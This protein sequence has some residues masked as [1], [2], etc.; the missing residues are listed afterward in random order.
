[1]EEKSICKITPEDI[2][3]LEKIAIGATAISIPASV[4]AAYELCLSKT[5]QTLM[6]EL[7]KY[8]S[9]ARYF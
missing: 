3:L 9:G 4:W 6:E 7:P 1:M 8:F 2:N 5:F